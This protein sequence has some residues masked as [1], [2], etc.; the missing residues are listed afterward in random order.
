MTYFLEDIA[1]Y[2]NK[3]T[4]GDFRNLIIVFPNRR[5]RLFFNNFLSRKIQKPVW[6][7]AY[8]TISD[9]VQKIGGMQI[10]DPLTLIFIF[11]SIYKEVT[12]SKENFDTFYYYCEMILADFDNIDKYLVDAKMLYSNLSDIKAFE[13]YSEYFSDEQLKAVRQFWESFTANPESDEKE[14]FISI[15]D[16]LYK[17]YFRFNEVLDQKNIAYEGK[18]YR[19]AVDNIKS[20]EINPFENKTIA[21]VGFNALNKSEE[22]LFAYF[23]RSGRALFFWDYDK[24]YIENEIHEAGYFLRKYIKRYPPPDDFLIQNSVRSNSPAIKTLAVPSNISQAKVVPYCLEILNSTSVNNPE[25][26]AIVLA[27]EGL[28]LPLVNSLPQTIQKVNI[29]MGYPVTDTSVYAFLVA[30]VDLQ[31]RRRAGTHENSYTYYYQD[32]FAV[33]NHYFLSE[34]NEQEEFRKFQKDVRERNRIYINPL[35]I[36]ITEPLYHKI[37]TMVDDPRK[38]GRYISEVLELVAKNLIST[39][40]EDNE[41]K[42]QLEIIYS[43]HKVLVRFDELLLSTGIQLSFSTVLNLMRRILAGI[44]VPFAGEPLTGLQIMGILE[45]RTLDFENLVI[46]SMNEGKFPKTG[47]VPSLIP[48]SIREGFDLPTIR[49]Q[50]A[51]FAYYF[52]RLL[53]RVKNLLLVYNTKSEGLQKGEPSRYLYQLRFSADYK[54]EQLNAG[55]E[56]SSLPNNTI[57]VWKSPDVLHKL[58]KYQRPGGESFLS[59]SALNIYLNCKLRF[60]FKYIEGLKEKEDITEDIEASVFG[61]IL[62]SVMDKLYSGFKGIKVQKSQFEELGKDKSRIDEAINNAFA[63][64]F[65]KKSTIN[66]R[67]FQGRLL[68]VREVI[69]KY[70]KGIIVFDARNAPIKIH[71]LEK[72]RNIEIPLSERN[73]HIAL[74]GIIDRIDEQEGVLRIVD[75]KTGRK[76]EVFLSVEELFTAKPTERNSAVF[77]TFLYTWIIG[78]KGEFKNLIPAL[79]YV[80]NIY[81]QNFDW[82]IYQSANRKRIAVDDFEG[83][84]DEFKDRLFLL[85]NELF[86]SDIPFSQTE[87]VKYC[88]HCPYNKICMRR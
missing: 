84:R 83:Y 3:V 12:G 43:I 75:Y 28:L 80:R 63:E 60:Y 37:F 56:V 18:A 58:K 66:Q 45:T 67:D 73:T 54:T 36:E 7:P 25:R 19:K 8:Y 78:E 82:R 23:K 42:W 61:S 29:S 17:M 13:N 15:W 88:E 1:G 57:L 77:Q 22:L 16:A 9:F 74:G 79:Y 53:H 10:A 4:K 20:E 38:L 55:Y 86:G 33:M 26:T 31:S 52:Y 14:K 24:S 32:Y 68:I 59:P 46:L 87:D 62:H 71:S 21:F 50:D 65:F 2:L 41:L 6:A 76:K 72:H 34:L 64:E 44:S 5:A 49:H 11:F 70:V 81:S 69:E 48:F 39:D 40:R 85:I 35:W 51:I 27:D 30:L 47:H